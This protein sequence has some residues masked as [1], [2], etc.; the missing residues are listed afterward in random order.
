MCVAVH[1]SGL[2]LSDPSQVP[3]VRTPREGKVKLRVTCNCRRLA[4]K[5]QHEAFAYGNTGQ[6]GVK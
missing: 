4:V 6:A 2:P 5:N 3:E 1:G